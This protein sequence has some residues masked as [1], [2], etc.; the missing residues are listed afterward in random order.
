MKKLIRPRNDRML[1]GVCASVA[2]YF[3]IDAT[4]VR[5]GAVV[6]AVCTLGTALVLYGAGWLVI[7]QDDVNDSTV[8]AS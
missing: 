8:W 1:A 4:L 5:I 3:K 7:P 6:L 2:N